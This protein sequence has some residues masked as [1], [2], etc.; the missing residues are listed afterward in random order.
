MDELKKYIKKLERENANQKSKNE[1]LETKNELL[2]CKLEREKDK[3]SLKLKDKLIQRLEHQIEQRDIKQDVRKEREEKRGEERRTNALE[4]EN[5]EGTLNTKYGADGK[6]ITEYMEYVVQS[7]IYPADDSELARKI[8]LILDDFYST[9]AKEWKGG[10]MFVKVRGHVSDDLKNWMTVSTE[11]TDLEEKGKRKKYLAKKMEFYVRGELMKFE[12]SDKVFVIKEVVIQIFPP[13]PSGGCDMKTHHEYSKNELN[14][15]KLLN[16]KSKWNNCFFMC[17][18][19]SGKVNGVSFSR[20]YCN[21]I[22]GK[23]GLAKDSPISIDKAREIGKMEWNLNIVVR[24]NDL[25]PISDYVNEDISLVLIHDHFYLFVAEKKTCPYCAVEWLKEHNIQACYARSAKRYVMKN[26]CRVV[27]P[28]NLTKSAT[29][30]YVENKAFSHLPDD[31]RVLHYD[32]EAWHLGNYD[33]ETTD[34]KMFV[35]N[36][37]AM[38]WRDVCGKTQTKFIGGDS[39]MAEMIAFLKTDDVSHIKYLDAF[40]GSGY[41]HHFLVK[42]EQ[43][44]GVDVSKQYLTLHGAEILTGIVC[45]KI[46]V[47]VKKHTGIGSLKQRLKDFGC[48]LT[49][50]DWEHTENRKWIDLSDTQREK[51]RVYNIQDALCLL[52]LSEVVNHGAMLYTEGKKVCGE[53]GLFDTDGVVWMRFLST[54]QATYD[55][56]SNSDTM[57]NLMRE[58]KYVVK[59]TLGQYE[60]IHHA[61]YGGRCEVYKHYYESPKYDASK[62]AYTKD[63]FEAIKPEEYLAYVDTVSLYPASMMFDFPI[64]QAER[65]DVYING[66]LGVYKCKYKANKALLVSPLPRREGNRIMWDVQDGEGYYTSVDIENATSFGYTFDIINGFYWEESVPVFREYIERCF[67]DKEREK[68]KGRKGSALYN[69]AKLKMNGLYGKC[70]QKPRFEETRFVS[71]NHEWLK[72]F[73]DYAVMDVDMNVSPNSVMVKIKP[74]YEMLTEKKITKPSHLSMFV[75]AYSRKIMSQHSRSLNP[76]DDIERMQFYTDTDSIVCLASN[77]FNTDGSVKDGVRFGSSLGALDDELGG[78]KIVRATFYTRKFYCLEYVKL[79][80]KNGLYEL[81]VKLV[82][83]G[84]PNDT[85]CLEDYSD[86]MEGKTVRKS[87]QSFKK[88]AVK[89]N[90]TDVLKGIERF[91]VEL[92]YVSRTIGKTGYDGREFSGNVSLPWGTNRWE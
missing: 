88:R 68:A 43:Q 13:L 66:K 60:Y 9:W 57:R 15:C 40:N 84:V 39:C 22:R 31:W 24:N 36:S 83:K 81:N 46:L 63:E 2:Q 30:G 44:T 23:Y 38:A 58:K 87:F 34:P 76:E 45:G 53:M 12:Q 82:G 70:G 21:A 28:K 54:S 80:K 17:V 4:D 47:D 55:I 6:L 56:W 49:K 52:E 8:Q 14:G 10:F 74:R 48:K 89:L 7:N 86:L 92:Q 50:G 64:G 19:L 51:M 5:I 16:P 71:S 91:S 75:L 62:S 29:R 20:E 33:A 35:P 67:S 25:V 69:L 41:D 90:S 59:P 32:I 27:L 26:K 61:S 85:L 77:V 11:R 3:H 78:G 37:V 1:L 18:K 72:L 42:E 65:T 79:N 73:V